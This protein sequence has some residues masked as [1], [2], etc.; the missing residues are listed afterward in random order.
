[1][2]DKVALSSFVYSVRRYVFLSCFTILGSGLE[3]VVCL[4][5]PI[6]L[7]EIISLCFFE[8]FEGR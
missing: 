5:I 8:R 3:S 4:Q 7:L 1:M 6:F 2:L